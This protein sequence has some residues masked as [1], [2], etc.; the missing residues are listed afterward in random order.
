MKKLLLILA[1]AGLYLSNAEA[2]KSIPH[3]VVRSCPE[4]VS[5]RTEIILPKVKGYNCY[6]ADFHTHTIYSDGRVSPK[7][8][9]IEAWMDGLDILAITDHYEARANEKNFFKV[10]A[11]YNEDGKPTERVYAGAYVMPENGI[12]PGVKADF[13]AIHEEAVAEQRYLGYPLLLIKGC[14]FGRNTNDKGH[15]NALFVKDLNSLYDFNLEESFRKVHKQGGIVIHNHPSYG[16]PKGSTDKSEWDKMVYSEGLIDGVE[17]ANG[18]NFY[19]RMVRRCVEEKL[20]MFGNTDEHR[21]TS[22][23]FNRNGVYRTMTFV[24]AKELTEK[25]VKDA[26]LK[27]RTIAYTGGTLI[28]EDMWLSEFLNEAVICQMVKEDT[29]KGNRTFMLT[30]TSSISFKL[31]RGKNIFE[32]EPFKSM[33]VSFGKDKNSGKYHEPKFHIDNMWIMDYK[34]PEIAIKIDERN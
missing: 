29:K 31:R 10:L 2:Q 13:N 20:T 12:D 25:A 9:V 6:K 30:N 1:F 14:E 19:P 8:R 4:V 21:F 5:P 17:V 18:Y 28:G 26:I 3:R 27:R 34:H 33:T 23:R 16:R 24:F 32:L 11:P 15:F 22:Y 7:G